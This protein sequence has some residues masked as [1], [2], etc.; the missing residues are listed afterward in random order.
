MGWTSFLQLDEKIYPW[1]VKLFYANSF[2]D[3]I[4]TQLKSYMLGTE[5]SL[6]AHSLNGIFVGQD[7]TRR[8]VESCIK[9]YLEKVSNRF[10]YQVLETWSA[11][12]I[13]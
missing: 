8:G 2:V 3:E 4:G 11:E 9:N 6:N 1:H 7:K 5:I 10:L 12:V 13:C